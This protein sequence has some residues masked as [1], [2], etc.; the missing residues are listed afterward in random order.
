M[1]KMD[2]VFGLYSKSDNIFITLPVKSIEELLFYT[3]K[4]KELAD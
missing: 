3:R 2:K 1:D 4:L